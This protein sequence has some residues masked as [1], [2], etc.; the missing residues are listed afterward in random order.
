DCPWHYLLG[1]FSRGARPEEPAPLT[2]APSSP[3]MLF[4]PAGTHDRR[5]VR[6]NGSGATSARSGPLRNRGNTVVRSG[7]R[8]PGAASNSQVL[9]GT[10]LAGVHR[11]MSGKPRGFPACY[12]SGVLR[13]LTR[14]RAHVLLVAALAMVFE[15][16][17]SQAP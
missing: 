14:I 10:C 2:R 1:P 17:C 15:T 8:R 5:A 9:A 7:C 13:L 12:A 3:R 16:G 11:A 4:A 6:E